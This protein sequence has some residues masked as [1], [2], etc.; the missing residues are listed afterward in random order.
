MPHRKIDHY[1]VV[2]QTIAGI[3][4]GIAALIA[5]NTNDKSAT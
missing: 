4:A 5:K 3:E 2:R 1:R